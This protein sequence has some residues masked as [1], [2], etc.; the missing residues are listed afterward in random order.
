MFPIDAAYSQ[1]IKV[2][3]GEDT[4]RLT[5][6]LAAGASA[7]AALALVQKVIRQGFRL[8]DR[9][10]LV[11]KY[12]DDEGDLCT[13]AEFCLEDLATLSKGKPWK[14]QA[15]LGAQ[16]AAAAAAPAPTNAPDQAAPAPAKAPAQA[17]QVAD[18][19][20]EAEPEGGPTCRSRAESEGSCPPVESDLADDDDESRM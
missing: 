13:L 10:D 19:H 9:D 12:L 8:S 7:A 6:D 5:I 18:A 11:L 16:P 15:S 4:R 2:S 14:I 20:P 1:T 3:L 17:A